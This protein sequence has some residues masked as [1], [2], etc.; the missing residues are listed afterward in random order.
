MPS[1]AAAIR[2]PEQRETYTTHKSIPSFSASRSIYLR[3]YGGNMSVN[4]TLVR[5]VAPTSLSGARS[6]ARYPSA[7]RL[8]VSAPAFSKATAAWPGLH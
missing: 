6:M 5:F 2:A 7:S 4:S 3:T 1:I 8:S